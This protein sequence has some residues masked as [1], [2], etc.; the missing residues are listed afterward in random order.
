[1]DYFGL[2]VAL[3]YD[4]WNTTPPDDDRDADRC[5]SCGA[6]RATC[7]CEPDQPIWICRECGRPCPAGSDVHAQCVPRRP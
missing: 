4:A 2:A 5:E 6:D 3:S 7:A 1:M